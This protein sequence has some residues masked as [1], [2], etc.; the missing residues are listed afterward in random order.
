MDNL[1]HTLVGAALAE[2]GLR[3]RTRFGLLTLVVASNLPDIDVAVFLTPV[4]SVAF[5]RGWTHG[6]PAQILLPILLTLAMLWWDRR[7]PL[8]AAAGAAVGAGAGAGPAPGSTAAST[9]GPPARAGWLLLLSVLGVLSHVGLDYLNNY[10]VRLLMPWSGR[11][12]YGDVLFIV[13]PWLYLFLGGGWWLARRKGRPGL[14]AAGLLASALYIA[15]LVPVAHAA[16]AEVLAQ[17]TARA[18][19]APRALMVGPLPLTPFHK[20]VI[21]DRGDGYDVGWYAMPGRRLTLTSRLSTLPPEDPAV[22]RALADHRV[23]DVLV[24]SRFPRFERED[25]PDGAAVRLTDIRFG[26]LRGAGSVRVP[27]P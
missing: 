1:C 16:R 26:R 2:T 23:R 15:L 19:R 10:G 12:F 3:R 14:A 18:G 27:L 8:P 20:Q 21:V 25:G 13:D 22:V 11:W 17:W 4:S 7:R 6:V 9:A 24:W 5:R